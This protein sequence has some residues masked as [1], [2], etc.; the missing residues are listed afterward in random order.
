MES[1]DENGQ[2]RLVRLDTPP[3]E[4]ANL[5]YRA[6][7]QQVTIWPDDSRIPRVWLTVDDHGTD[8]AFTVLACILN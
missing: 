4:R 5:R 7:C 1:L 3:A 2:F 8:E 6:R